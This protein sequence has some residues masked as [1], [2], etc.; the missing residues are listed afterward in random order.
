LSQPGAGVNYE[1]LQVPISGGAPVKVMDG[2]LTNFAESMDGSTLFYSRGRAIWKRPSEGG[3]EQFVAPTSDIWDVRSD[4]LYLLTDSSSIERYSFD[5]KRLSRVA[6]LG[7]FDVKFPMSISP[8]ARWAL[9]GYRQ[10]QT[11]EID[12]IQHFD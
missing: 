8:D 3:A 1:L 12:M 10:R 5:G 11:V 7:H 6:T 4:G 2:R 9:L